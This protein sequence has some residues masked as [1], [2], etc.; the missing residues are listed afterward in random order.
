MAAFLQPFTNTSESYSNSLLSLTFSLDLLFSSLFQWTTLKLLYFIF[1]VMKRT[2]SPKKQKI[3]NKRLSL[4]L[5]ATKVYTIFHTSNK[6]SKL[7]IS[8]LLFYLSRQ[9]P[10]SHPA[11]ANDLMAVPTGENTHVRASTPLP[12]IM[13][14]EANDA[15]PSLSV[16]LPGAD[17]PFILSGIRVLDLKHSFTFI[18][19]FR[20]KS[21]LLRIIT[22][23]HPRVKIHFNIEPFRLT[24]G[25][26]RRSS[27]SV[28]DMCEKNS[29]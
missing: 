18:C 19:C 15:T 7:F 21:F 13:L 29:F 1:H 6:K 8:P 14:P 5:S 27:A 28:Q 11:A 17:I 10:A 16:P 3:D 25:K 4:V 12:T 23:A 9:A 2:W 22:L 20:T 24:C 26:F